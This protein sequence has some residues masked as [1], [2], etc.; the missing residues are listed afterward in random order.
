MYRYTTSGASNVIRRAWE[1]RVTWTPTP[2]SSTIENT[3]S[4]MYAQL[5]IGAPARIRVMVKETDPTTPAS[6][7]SATGSATP[8]RTRYG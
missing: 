7:S 3:T 6:T 8:S 5:G 4:A 2:R 1:P